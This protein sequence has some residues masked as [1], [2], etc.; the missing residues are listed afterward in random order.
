MKA[1]NAD[2]TVDAG[3]GNDTIQ[4][5]NDSNTVNNIAAALTLIG[6]NDTDTITITDSGDTT[7]NTGILTS[8]TLIGLGMTNGGITYSNGETLNINLGSG[9]D[10]FTINST[11]AN[12]SNL[13]IINAGA[14]NDNLQ[15]TNINGLNQLV[16]VGGIGNDS[17][18]VQQSTNTHTILVGDEASI[19]H[20][21]SWLSQIT[22]NSGNGNDTITLNSGKNTVLAGAGTD[23]ITTNNG[24]NR[25]ILLGDN[26]TAKFSTGNLTQITSTDNSIGGQDIIQ[27]NGGTEN[28]VIGGAGSDTITNA[29]PG[30]RGNNDS[31]VI[32]TDEADLIVTNDGYDITSINPNNGGNDT[33]QA[34][35]N[36]QK[37]VVGGIG[38][39]NITTGKGNDLITGGNARIRRIFNGVWNSLITFISGT[40]TDNDILRGGDGNDIIYGQAGDDSLYGEAGDDVLSGDEGSDFIDGGAG[41]DRMSYQSSASGVIVNIV[42]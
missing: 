16:V 23:T 42:V 28:L 41:T 27:L 40:G 19:Q 13:V 25:N 30:N 39:D 9:A 29:T 11:T 3:S 36:A 17:L 14:G 12:V 35:D 22:S 21:D 37:V 31:D 26:G 20:T 1:I 34:P 15:V 18:T 38:N 7:A 4:I 6:G 24:T 8:T 2:T 33:V 32:F 5:Y 10:N